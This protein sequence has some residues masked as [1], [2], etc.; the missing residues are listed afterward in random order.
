MFPMK[1]IGNKEFYE[2][3]GAYKWDSDSFQQGR[4]KSMIKEISIA[5]EGKKKLKIL[6]VAS[7]TGGFVDLMLHKY[8]SNTYYGDDISEGIIS[9]NIKSKP[10]IQWSVQDYNHEIAYEDNFFDIIIAGEIIEHLYDTDKF[11]QNCLRVLKP[12]GEL[13]ITT[14]NLASWLDRIMLLFGM[15]PFSTEV[16]NVNRVFGRESFYKLLKQRDNSPSAGHLRLFTM[17]S[18]EKVMIYHGGVLKKSIPVYIH[19]FLLNRL[20]TRFLPTMSQGTYMIFSK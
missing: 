9:R 10:Q 20:I 16:S 7:G 8:P 12:G 15:Q 6:D 4:V 11:I 3:Q 1:N 5:L 19:N 17:A 18:L 2:K 13:H 14:P